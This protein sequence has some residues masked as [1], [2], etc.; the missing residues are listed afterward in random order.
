M[1]SRRSE[2]RRRAALLAGRSGRRRR[3]ALLAAA[4]LL[5]APA[6]AAREPADA[7][8]LEAALARERDPEPLPR[9]ELVIEPG[10]MRRLMAWRQRIYDRLAMPPGD[11]LWVPAGFRHA[12]V[13]LPAKIRIRGDLPLHWRGDRQSLRV[14]FRREL[15]RGMKEINLILPWDKYYGVELLQS[16]IAAEIGLPHFANRFVH[17]SV[18][19]GEEALYL[20]N[21]HPT[22]EYL[23][24]T[25][26]PASSIFTFASNWTLYMSQPTYHLAFVLPGS[27]QLLPLEGIGQIKQ[28]RTYE[29][30]DPDLAKKQLAYAMEFH[31]LMT[32]GTPESIAARAPLYLDLENFAAYVALQDFF[33][34]NHATQLNDNIRLYLDPTSGKLLFMPWDTSLLSLEERRSDPE[35][36]AEALLTPVDAGFRAVL[37]G[38]PGVRRERDRVL[39]GLVADADRWRA[40]LSRIH[41]RLIRLHPADERLRGLAAD[42]DERMRRNTA[43]LRRAL[44]LPGGEPPRLAHRGAAG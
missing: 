6:A 28:R 37:T 18:N 23:E 43:L 29:P 1:A 44:G 27:R 20:E 33:G 10:A 19:G 41:A 24:R 34:S 9:Y 32:K 17:V 31:R 21:E 22:R 40:E 3:A 13:H 16:E 35:A 12:G 8:G 39:R 4:L 42:L 36:P 30:G 26:R 2:R 7:A 5:A 38:V 25:G 14:K 15:F 11:R